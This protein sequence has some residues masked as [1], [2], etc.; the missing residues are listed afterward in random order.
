MTLLVLLQ[1]PLWMQRA[2]SVFDFRLEASEG[3]AI[4]AQLCGIAKGMF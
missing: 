4:Q 1:H 2:S 3:T